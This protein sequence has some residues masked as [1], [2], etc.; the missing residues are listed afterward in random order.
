MKKIIA[1]FSVIIFLIFSLIGCDGGSSGSSGG[2]S[3]GSES[4]E[5]EV[6][7]FTEDEVE[8]IPPESAEEEVEVIPPEDT[9]E[10]IPVQDETKIVSIELKIA[11]QNAYVGE[12]FT[13][14]LNVCGL[15]NKTAPSLGVFSLYIL[16]DPTIIKFVSVDYGHDLEDPILYSDKSNNTKF[17]GF[18]YIKEVSFSSIK[19]LN[20][21][22]PDNFR[23]A[24]LI[25]EILLIDEILS[26][27]EINLCISDDLLGDADANKIAVEIN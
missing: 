10:E 19:D 23:L 8:A 16:Y 7:V 25:F 4:A 27:N 12:Y 9:E 17:S 18:L 26:T 22:Q 6:S 3:S 21:F 11:D 14:D 20:D 15:G 1:S 5:E 24:T 13:V 2:G